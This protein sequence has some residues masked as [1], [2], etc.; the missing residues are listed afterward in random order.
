[1]LLAPIAYSPIRGLLLGEVDHLSTDDA[2][3]DPRFSFPGAFNAP[4]VDHALR[5]RIHASM[6]VH[7]QIIGAFSYSKLA[8]AAYGEA[9]LE[10][11]RFVTDLLSPYFFA[12]RAAEQAQLSVIIETGASAR[13]EGLR[14]GAL[15]LTG[16]L[17]VLPVSVRG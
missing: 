5:S 1:M 13:E 7:G 4:I 10:S 9:D 12:L 8:T 6:M 11:A 15:K 2:V 14:L 3:N 17:E 16:A